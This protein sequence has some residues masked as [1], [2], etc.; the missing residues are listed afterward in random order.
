MKKYLFMMMSA[1]L[2][3][4]VGMTS[5]SSED[6][7]SEDIDDTHC[8]AIRIKWIEDGNFVHGY[9]INMP[10]GAGFEGQCSLIIDK[11]DLSES[12]LMDGD[13]LDLIILSSK[14][15]P[16]QGY[17]TGIRRYYQIK[18]KPCK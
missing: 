15:I 8:Y 17:T 10:E 6:V 7:G 2:I 9:F 5:C 12:K 1:M 13:V 3:T 16:S 4:L 18:V 11:A 14:E